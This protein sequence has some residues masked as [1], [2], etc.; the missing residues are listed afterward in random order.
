MYDQ[1]IQRIRDALVALQGSGDFATRFETPAMGLAIEVEGVGSFRLPP[2]DGELQ[3]ILSHAVPSPFGHRDQTLHDDSVRTSKEIAASQVRLDDAWSVRLQRG[4]DHIVEAL[5]FPEGVALRAVLHKLVLYEE[6]GFFAPH[7]DT[8]RDPTMWGSMVVALPGSYEGGEL[9]A[10]HAGEEK[11]FDSSE[12]AAARRLVFLGFYPD[13]VHE[14]RPVTS[15]CRMA[16]TFS[17]HATSRA[18]RPAPEHQRKELQRRLASFFTGE[19]WLVVLLDHAYTQ[20][21]FGW[22]DLKHH[23]RARVEALRRI[24]AE[25]GCGCFLAFADVHESFDYPEEADEDGELEVS[26]SSFGSRLEGELTLSHW[27]DEEGRP[28]A[29][30]DEPVHDPCIVSVVDS[31]ARTPYAVE[32]EGWTGNEGGS[33]AQWYHQAALVMVRRDSERYEAVRQAEA[34]APDPEAPRRV[35]RRR[36]E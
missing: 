29:G 26:R 3:A 28:C 18:R 4:I 8:E 25:L 13:C 15:G 5:G 16:L 32:G 24:A 27:H 22:S 10:R 35:V 19:T 11:V 21:R 20:Q 1:Q 9:V 17:L 31:M 34:P 6:G 30:T 36:R 12:A 7:R 23:D 2:T 33:A 14:I